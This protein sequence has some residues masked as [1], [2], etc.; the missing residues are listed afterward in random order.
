MDQEKCRLFRDDHRSS[1]PEMVMKKISETMILSGH[2]YIYMCLFVQ[3][4]ALRRV[5]N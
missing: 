2:I 5:P 1:F 4:I 3:S